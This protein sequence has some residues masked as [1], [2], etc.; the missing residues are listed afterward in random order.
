MTVTQSWRGGVAF[1]RRNFVN[2]VQH[3][4]SHER[5]SAQEITHRNAI[6]IRI[7]RDNN[8][9]VPLRFNINDRRW[10]ASSRIGD[11]LDVSSRNRWLIHRPESETN[12]TSYR[13]EDVDKSPPRRSCKEIKDKNNDK[14]ICHKPR[15]CVYFDSGIDPVRRFSGEGRASANSHSGGPPFWILPIR[16]ASL[17]PLFR[18]EPVMVV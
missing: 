8:P 17:T 2:P 16:S 15:L 6:E 18:E 10:D 7:G 12:A 1:R 4:R 3:K 9:R 13:E 5:P 14:H 11:W